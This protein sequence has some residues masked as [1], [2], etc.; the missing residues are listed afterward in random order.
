MPATIRD[1]MSVTPAASSV[2]QFARDTDSFELQGKHLT[3]RSMH[4]SEAVVAQPGSS[5]PLTGSFS[6]TTS[7]GLAHDISPATVFNA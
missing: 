3:K 5:A 2:E 4:G 7:T 6:W 1:A